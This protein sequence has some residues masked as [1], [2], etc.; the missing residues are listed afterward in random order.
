MIH[1]TGHN[2]TLT[3]MRVKTVKTLLRK[4]HSLA[5]IHALKF[6]EVCSYQTLVA[7]VKAAGISAKHEQQI[8]LHGLRAATHSLIDEIFDPKDRVNARLKFLERYEADEIDTDIEV[9]DTDAIR[10]E[11]LRDLNV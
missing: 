11:I 2:F 6:E 9:V 3:E 10:D 1:G 8:G 4:Q 5:S 7:H